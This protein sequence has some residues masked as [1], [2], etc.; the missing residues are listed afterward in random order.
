MGAQ[1]L[2]TVVGPNLG[3]TPSDDEEGKHQMAF[4][5]SSKATAITL[6]LIDHLTEVFMTP[7]RYSAVALMEGDEEEPLSEYVFIR[8][9]QE[10]NCIGSILQDGQVLEINP[11]DDAHCII[12]HSREPNKSFAAEFAIHGTDLIS[13][14]KSL[15]EPK[16]DVFSSRD[17]VQS[18]PG[19][20]GSL[21]SMPTLTHKTLPPPIP[22]RPKHETA[23]PIHRHDNALEHLLMRVNALE[24]KV[25]ELQQSLQQETQKREELSQVVPFLMRNQDDVL[26]LLQSLNISNNK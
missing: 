6:Y 25:A 16:A 10:G 8:Y 21:A 1:N 5:S 2:A 3:W 15:Y 12:L 26:S 17:S 19:S 24:G 13:S 11:L 7:E 22:E 14:S 4:I 23:D 9:D 20:L 18:A